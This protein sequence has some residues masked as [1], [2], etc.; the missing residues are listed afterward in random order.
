MSRRYLF[1]GALALVVMS[2]LLSAPAWADPLDPVQPPPSASSLVTATNA[3]LR[4]GEVV[5]TLKGP[6]PSY[7][8]GFATGFNNPPGGGD[9]PWVCD[10]VRPS[11]TPVYVPSAQASGFF[12][13]SGLVAQYV[14]EYES[15]AAA[16]RA[17]AALSEDVAARCDGASSPG[18]PVVITVER[19]AGIAEPGWG[20]L[21]GDSGAAYSTVHLL[22]NAIQ[23]VNL[24]KPVDEEANAW[25]P[26][27]SGAVAAVQELSVALAQRWLARA[28]LPLT[29]EPL[30]TRAESSML[31]PGDVDSSLPILS[32]QAGAWSNF[33]SR[34]P[35][36]NM[37][38]PCFLSLADSVPGGEQSF[39]ASLGSTGS[40]ITVTREGNVFQWVSVFASQQAAEQAWELITKQ[41]RSCSRGQNDPIAGNENLQRVTNGTSELSYGGTP[42]VWVRQLSTYGGSAGNF[43]EKAYTIYLFMGDAIQQV[44]YITGRS[45]LR[46]VPLDQLPVN[47]VAEDLANRWVAAGAQ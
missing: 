11:G 32:P 17:W 2:S 12:A 14:Y 3:M 42:G 10:P 43:S 36:S 16:Q 6:T 15:E 9:P 37:L 7:L 41:A 39:S 25:L 21:D 35:A 8:R 40:A 18:S 24:S 45:G 44:T 28:T 47:Q 23:L 20:V 1:S 26:T 22:S 19:I 31:R 29:Q 38:S 5:D 33:D 34:Q 30:L 13:R 4:P 27:P 46:Q